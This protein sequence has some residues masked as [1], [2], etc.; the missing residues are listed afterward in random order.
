MYRFLVLFLLGLHLAF[1]QNY[2]DPGK[3]FS[4][5]MAKE[6][7]QRLK[8]SG[9]FRWRMDTRTGVNFGRDPDL[10][11]PL[12]R[13]RLGVEVQAT[14]WLKLSAMTQDARAPLYGTAAPA[15]VR[16][17]LDL[18][19]SYAEFFADRKTGFGAVVGRQRLNFG[20]TRLLGVPDWSNVARSYD[21]V[22]TY[23]RLR[24]A[25]LEFLFLS[26]VKVRVDGFDRPVLGDRVWGFY[27]SF[28][29]LLGK[30]VVE[31]YVLRHDQN[32]AGG[33]AG[34]G[35]LRINNYGGRLVGPLPASLRYSIETA[36]QEGDVGIRSHRAFAWFSSVSRAVKWRWP[37]TLSA[38]YKYASGSSNP[39]GPRSETFDQLYPAN[40]DKFGHA[41][42]F[43]W[44]NIHNVRALTTFQPNKRWALNLMYNNNW[45]ASAR[46]AL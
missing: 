21:T 20:E 39:A 43:G 19:E 2:L 9:E 32:R 12:F 33:F 27:H 11:N 35:R 1:A 31:A 44:R 29:E 10:D 8:F 22:R 38:E 37:V 45:L 36:V 41:D 18:Y 7:D 5:W 24:R 4:G 28:P 25:R 26:P 16:N 46:D 42:L 40:H 30:G 14:N 6:T 15:T 23:Y 34:T 17:P 3:E 13:T